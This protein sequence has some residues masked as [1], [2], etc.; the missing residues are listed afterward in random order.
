MPYEPDVGT[1]LHRLIEVHGSDLHL[2]VGSPPCMRIDGEIEMR[3][4]APSLRPDDTHEMIL[5]LL[6]TGQR[7]EFEEEHELDFAYA[8]PGL[9][10]F[11]VNVFYQR[12]TIGAGLPHD[13]PPHPHRGGTRPAPDRPRTGDE[14]PGTRAR[15]R[16]DRLGQVDHPRGHGRPR[17]QEP[18][19]PHHDHRGPHRV[20]APGPAGHR[21]PARGGRR[22]Q[23]L[24]AGAQ[25]GCCGRTPTSS[26]WARCATSRPSR[27]PAPP[28][29]PAT[30]SSA[31]CTPPRRPRPSTASSTSSRPISRSRSACSSPS[32]CRG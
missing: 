12:G 17:Q 15:D 14:A 30:W 29:R 32:A 7:K 27:P 26:W 16:A 1:L 22:H 20:P 24:R 19:V 5:G 4:R 31:R 6:N 28:P 21:Q 18:Q 23:E 3:R 25:D 11:R 2:K 13:P 8:I 10:R 9:S